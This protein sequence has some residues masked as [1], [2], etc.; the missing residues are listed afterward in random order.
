MDF[1]LFV[2][3]VCAYIVLQTVQGT[4]VRSAVYGTVYYAELLKSSD[5]SRS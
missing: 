4:G 1:Q 3:Q 2:I 5:K